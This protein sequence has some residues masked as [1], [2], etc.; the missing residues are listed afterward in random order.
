MK[1]A[2]VIGAS[3]GI[4]KELAQQL[5]NDGWTIGVAARRI[6]VLNCWKEAQQQS[7]MQQMSIKK[8][9]TPRIFTSMIDVCQPQSTHHLLTLIEQMGGVDLYIH[10]SGVGKQNPYLQQ[11][12]ELNTVRTNAVGFTQMI[13]TVFRYMS[14]HG[15][16][17]IAVVSSIAG[18]KGLA[19]APAYSAT[20]AF[21]NTYIQALEQLSYQQNLNIK[22]TDLRPGFVDTALLSGSN[23]PMMMDKTVVASKIL[24]A[25]YKYKH[26]AVIDWRWRMV[27]VLWRCI[28]NVLWRRLRLIRGVNK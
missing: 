24:R 25:I 11:D 3:S 17:H 13:T 5:L 8:R 27:V 21:Q 19:P 15:G 9:V 26:I 7:M 18:V 2:I 12:I 20:K 10:V 14:A 22:F 28:P 1:K 6:D 16:G 23:F 4:G